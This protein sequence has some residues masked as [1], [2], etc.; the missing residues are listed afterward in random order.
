VALLDHFESIIYIF[1]AVLFLT[2]LRMLLP[3]RETSSGPAW[4]V[5]L[6]GRFLPV[7]ENGDG[8]HFFLRENGK[9]LATSLFLALLTIEAMDVVFAADSIP[10][11]LAIT[12]DTFIAYSSNVFAVLGLRAIYF[13]LAGILRRVRFLHQGLAAVLIFTGLKMVF[14]NRFSLPDE[15]SLVVIGSIFGLTALASFCWPAKNTDKEHG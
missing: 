7:T 13:V 10:A 4:I 2:A 5:R 15:W 9:W 1:G 12:R 8:E 14:S 3:R 11:V 6:T